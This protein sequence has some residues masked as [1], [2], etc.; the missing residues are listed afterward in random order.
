M[1]TQ[2]HTTPY[3][4]VPYPTI[5]KRRFVTALGTYLLIDICMYMLRTY[6]YIYVYI[7]IYIYMYTHT[8]AYTYAY[9]YTYTYTS[10]YVYIYI[11]IYDSCQ[12]YVIIFARFV[13]ALET[14]LLAFCSRK[15]RT[16]LRICC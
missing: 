16:P 3:H 1:N 13:T 4:T 11:Y 2:Y 7:Y 10:I 14:Y 5:P 9:T 15:G 6:I 12:S 8:Y